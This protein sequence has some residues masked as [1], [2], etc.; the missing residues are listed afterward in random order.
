MFTALFALVGCRAQP[1]KP[2]S[3]TSASAPATQTSGPILEGR[4]V[5]EQGQPV[6][7]VKVQAWGGFA[8]RFKGPETVTDADGVYH[9]APIQVNS[10]LEAS[11]VRP[12]S[13]YVGVQLYHPKLASADGHYWWDIEVPIAAGRVTRRDFTMVPAGGIEGWLTEA[14][15]GKP[16][17]KIG[18]RLSSPGTDRVSYFRYAETDDNGHFLET[19]L[20]PG[21]YV[22]DLNQTQPWYP[23]VGEAEIQREV[24]T[25]IRMTYA[26]PGTDR[27]P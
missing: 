12:A 24:V 8:T 22:I 4:I 3:P 19:G 5:D 7:G 14:A 18:L 16:L 15:T 20:Y 6:P 23:V 11:A 1:E 9:F 10:V 25:Q 27:R 21:H 13:Y 26:K 17:A 2:S